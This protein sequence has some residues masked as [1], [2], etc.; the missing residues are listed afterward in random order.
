MKK[1]ITIG[2]VDYLGNGRKANAVELSVE[3]KE[4]SGSAYETTAHE[5]VTSYVEFSMSGAIWHSN[6]AD[7]YTRGQNIE[8]IAEFFPN[9]ARV[10]RLAAIWR[11]WHLNGMTPGCDHQPEEWH[12][13]NH[14]TPV[15]C[16][17]PAIRDEFGEYPYPQRGDCCPVC[18]RNRW[19]EPTDS[20]PET[21]Y[22]YGTRW[23]VR[24]LPVEIEDEIRM[25]IEL[26]D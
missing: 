8:E 1:T 22:R 24:I 10:Q 6:R 20:C 14:E 21:G 19:D 17:W 4:V 3:L 13:T 2:K 18:G 9:N 11:E 12:C 26:G 7:V 15:R 25:L 23:L 5:M 16:G